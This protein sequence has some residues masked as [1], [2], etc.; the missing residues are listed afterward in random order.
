ML[1]LY[2]C[3]SKAIKNYLEGI[4]QSNNCELE[5]TDQEAMTVYLLGIMQQ[6]RKVKD[7]HKFT[8]DFLKDWFPKLPSYSAFNNRLNTISL[9]FEVMVSELL[10]EGKEQLFFNQWFAI[11]YLCLNTFSVTATVVGKDIRIPLA[12]NISE[13][14]VEIIG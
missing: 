5:F 6:Y 12:Y 13:R 8:E 14:Q 9:G 4:R 11:N 1:Y 3:E 2:I 7:I 10:K